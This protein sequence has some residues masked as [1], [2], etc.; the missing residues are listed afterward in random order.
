MQPRTDKLQNC[1]IETLYKSIDKM[2]SIE[3]K[4]ALK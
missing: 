2:N 4:K 1:W 3:K